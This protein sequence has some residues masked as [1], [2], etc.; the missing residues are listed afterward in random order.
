VRAVDPANARQIA[1]A[2]RDVASKADVLPAVAALSAQVRRQL[3]TSKS[4]M[5]RVAAAETF[6]TGS[7]DAMRAY[8]RGQEMLSAGNYQAA[9]K[10]FQEAVGLDARLG[11]A[12]SAMGAIYVNLKQTDRAEAAFK[13]AMNNIDRMSERERYRTFATYYVGVAG[14]YEKGIESYEQLIKSFPADNAAYGNLAVA[15]V[16]VGNIARAKEVAQRGLAIYPRNVLQRTNYAAYSVYAGDF[17]TAVREAE[18]VLGENAKYEYAYLPLALARVGQGDLPAARAA[19]TKLAEVSETG[20]SLAA[21]GVADLDLFAG[22]LG[23]ATERLRAG[24]PLDQKLGSSGELAAKHLA[25]AEA[26]QAAGQQPQAIAEAK[27]A[28]GAT[29][30]INVLVPAARVFIAAG[31]DAAARDVIKDLTNRLQTQTS[32]Y[33]EILEAELSLKTRDHARAIELLKTALKRQDLWLGRFILGRAYLEAGPEHAAEAIDEFNKCY[34]RRGEV[35]DVFFADSP[36]TR[37]LPPLYYWLG[38]AYQDKASSAKWL[39]QYV[40]VRGEAPQDPFLAD[41]RRRLDA[42]R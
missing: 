24:L 38:L 1:L 40:K 28:V 3:D 33:A 25:L 7:L 42:A 27:L 29:K 13:Q 23:E 39:G 12:Y 20:A 16:R 30:L 41:A 6:T 8:A 36:T 34:A 32:A 5:G 21:L 2:E 17:D 31:A 14:N 11:R 15:Y 19:Y 35:L 26:A 10:S 18:R 4:E 37:Y 22:R 9:L